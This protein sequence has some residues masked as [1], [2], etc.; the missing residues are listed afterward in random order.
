MS[1]TG[2]KTN[3]LILLV[4]Q[5]FGTGRAIVAPGTFGT[6][7]GLL[8]T[9][10]FML[11]GDLVAYLLLCDAGVL[12]SVYLSTR[13]EQILKKR[14]PGS[15]VIDEIIAVPICFAGWIWNKDQGLLGFP[16]VGRL[17]VDHFWLVVV[18]F[19]AFR[20]FDILK[21]WP[22]G[23]SQKFPRGWGVTIDDV[24]AAMYVNVLILL[25]LQFS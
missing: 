1:R 25:W 8:L 9:A 7:P 11:T 6:L 5:G 18:V 23:P 16:S 20:F 22:V 4:A 2:K 10:A 24:L 21:P 15:V 3:Q 17:F 12:A 13:A 14:D 19:A